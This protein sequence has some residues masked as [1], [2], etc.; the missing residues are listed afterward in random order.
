M[1]VIISIALI[2]IFLG[3][4]FVPKLE[5]VRRK[6]ADMFS[7]AFTL[8]A[9]FVGVFLAID[10]TNKSEKHKERDNVIKLLHASSLEISNTISRTQ[11]TLSV[12][13]HGVDSM[14]SSRH[15]IKNNPIQLPT[16][17]QTIIS[18][19]SVLGHLTET[20][21]KV[22]YN[23]EGNIQGLVEAINKGVAFN[24]SILLSTIEV[25]IKELQFTQKILNLEIA[26][27]EGEIPDD[28]IEELYDSFTTE[29]IGQGPHDIMT[30]I[31]EQAKRE[32]NYQNKN[33]NSDTSTK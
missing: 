3:L 16:L 12:A 7:F 6:H 21:I 24:D 19:E 18:N 15:H 2:V 11:T 1:Y 8:V 22:Y 32:K 26:H 23:T 27:L 5:Q 14:Y 20:G 4:S 13:I 9:T 33:Y 17:F 28:K 31:E 29:L 30:A 25:Y 10:L